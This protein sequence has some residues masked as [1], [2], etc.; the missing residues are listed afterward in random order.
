ML[1]FDVHINNK[2][3]NDEKEAKKMSEKKARNYI[4][5]LYAYCLLHNNIQTPIH[6]QCTFRIHANVSVG[7]VALQTQC[8]LCE[9]Q[10]Y[11][12][13]ETMSV[14]AQKYFKTL[15]TFCRSI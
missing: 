14:L 15:R 11:N 1:N 8:E 4:F 7:E 3:E 13:M 12:W 2:K 5:T 9:C 10:T 6:W